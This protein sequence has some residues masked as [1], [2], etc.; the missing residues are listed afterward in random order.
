[1]RAEDDLRPA[2]E[3]AFAHDD[4]ILVEEYVRGVEVESHAAGTNRVKG[5]TVKLS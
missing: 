3:L 1:V 5:A 4:K 2:V